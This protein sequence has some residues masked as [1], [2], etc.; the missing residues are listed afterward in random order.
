MQKV[1]QAQFS[2]HIITAVIKAIDSRFGEVLA[3][4]D[5]GMVASTIP[6]FCLWW[7]PPDEQEAM[8]WLLIKSIAESSDE[9]ST[10]VDAPQSESDED[11]FFT[12][13]SAQ[14]RNHSRERGA[15]V[16]PGP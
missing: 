5:A 4:H 2:A 9:A 6:K 15:E 14:M 16:P 12:F 7:L 13:R 3:S 1:T 8:K 11:D 10:R